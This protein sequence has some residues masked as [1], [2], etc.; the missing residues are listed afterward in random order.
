MELAFQCL[1]ADPTGGLTNHGS[2]IFDFRDALVDLDYRKA[3]WLSDKVESLNR[4]KRDSAA[5]LVGDD[6]KFGLTRIYITVS[7]NFFRQSRVFRD[8]AEAIR[9]LEI[10][11]D[12]CDEVNNSLKP[13][14][15]PVS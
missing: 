14:P 8:P 1:A 11:G 3:V 4:P 15:I 2:V 12:V 10:S 5:F 6:L 7:D 9:W 13:V